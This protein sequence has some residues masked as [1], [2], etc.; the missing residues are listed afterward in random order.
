MNPRPLSQG[1]MF[2]LC[3]DTSCNTGRINTHI[4]KQRSTLGSRPL[5]I[6]T[7]ILWELMENDLEYFIP[8]FFTYRSPYKMEMKQADKLMKVCFC[9]VYSQNTKQQRGTD[10]WLLE[11]RWMNLNCTLTKRGQKQRMK[12]RWSHTSWFGG[13]DRNDEWWWKLSEGDRRSYWSQYRDFLEWH[14][15][16]SQT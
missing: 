1:S 3:H 5:I 12:L 14:A 6:S 8:R 4:E 15:Q 10:R 13:R 16:F 2:P 11:H 7:L 9:V